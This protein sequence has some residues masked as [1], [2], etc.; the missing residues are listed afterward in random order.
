MNGNGPLG[1]LIGR[2]TQAG[3][4]EAEAVATHLDGIARGSAALRTGFDENASAGR[5]HRALNSAL[6]H[7]AS[8]VHGMRIRTTEI[9]SEAA[10][11]DRDIQRTLVSAR[12]QSA[13]SDAAG[14]AS[15]EVSATMAQITQEASGYAEAA[16][17]NRETAGLR[18]GELVEAAAGM[19]AVDA[20]IARFSHTVAE[21]TARSASIAQI[22]QL[23]RDIADQTNLLALNAAIEAARAGEAGRGFAVVA[24]EVRKLAERAK[25][26]TLA[27]VT[28]TGCISALVKETETGNQIVTSKVRSTREV[29]KLA[30]HGFGEILVDLSTTASGL[31]A[32]SDRIAMAEQTNCEIRDRIQQVQ[33]LSGEQAHSMEHSAQRSK[34]LRESSAAAQAALGGIVVGNTGYDQIMQAGRRIAGEV[35][36]CLSELAA[37]GV[38]VFDRQY[39]PI[40]NT[41]PPK[42]HTAY[43]RAAEKSL[44]AIFDR[45]LEQ[46]RGTTYC[47][48]VDPDGYAPTHNSRYSRPP[49]GDAASDLA[50]SR[51]KRKFSDPVGLAA[52]RL[53]NPCLVQTYLRD[54][55]EVLVDLSMPLEVNGRAWGG[56]R[57]GFPPS[58]LQSDAG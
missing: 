9:A 23:I 41:E 32:I 22:G 4:S 38:D 8:L 45:C 11:M 17:R 6:H 34:G 14:S 56:L 30:A 54:T 44:Q 1:A 21:L 25:Q 5:L 37:R 39:Q 51:D 58:V 18:Q 31:A 42:F 57:I 27:I 16:R 10:L 52:G 7:I 29:V 20:E 13:L 35:A 2:L 40:P 43:D 53:R 36:E 12:T 55:G 26:A 46:V 19:D 33:V 50:Q 24:D 47:L 15:S 28:D 49:S 48:I 3:K